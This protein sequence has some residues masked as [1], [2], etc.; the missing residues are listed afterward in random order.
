MLTREEL[1]QKHG[2]TWPNECFNL[3]CASRSKPLENPLRLR[4]SAVKSPGSIPFF[5][6]TNWACA[7]L[8]TSPKPRFSDELNASGKKSKK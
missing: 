3:R 5:A 8:A 4:Q 2:A 1:E 6:K 7:R